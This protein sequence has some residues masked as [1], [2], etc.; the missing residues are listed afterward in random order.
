M[1]FSI[2]RALRALPEGHLLQPCGRYLHDP[3]RVEEQLTAC[4]LRLLERQD[5][6]LREEAGCPVP[7]AFYCA[8]RL[9]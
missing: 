5:M 7:G 1:L 4:R 8:E 3:D 2:E 6:M 9:D